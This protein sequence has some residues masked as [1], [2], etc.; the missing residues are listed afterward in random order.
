VKNKLLVALLRCLPAFPLVALAGAAATHPV[1]PVDPA[2]P[3]FQPASIELS[4]ELPSI[5]SDA[6]G[7]VMQRWTEIYRRAHPKVTFP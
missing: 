3:S 2:I 4:G 5:G 7:T 1:P 6:M